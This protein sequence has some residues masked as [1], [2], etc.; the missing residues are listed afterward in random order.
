MFKCTSTL[1]VLHK[2]K[3]MSTMAT[4]ADIGLY[5]GG[6][7]YEIILGPSMQSFTLVHQNA[8]SSLFPTQICPT[9][10]RDIQLGRSVPS[11]QTWPSTKVLVVLVLMLIT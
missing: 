6:Y 1:A 11:Q 8:Q 2:Y 9:T 5:S 4:T 3:Q 10:I 7:T